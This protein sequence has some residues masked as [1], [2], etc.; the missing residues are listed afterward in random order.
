MSTDG[1]NILKVIKQTRSICEQISLLLRTIDEQMKKAGWNSEGNTAIV[2]SSLS[3]LQPLQWMPSD[4]FRFY[5]NE[6]CPN[7][8]AYVSVL[9]DDDKWK[10]YTIK[11]PLITAGFFD[12][13][14][15]KVGQQGDNWL[16]WYARYY[17][18]LA[19]EKGLNP[20]GH[21]FHFDPRTARTGDDWG[22]FESAEV[23]ALPLTTI[24]SSHDAKSKITDKLLELVNE[25]K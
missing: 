9:L 5:R 8:L 18:Y 21:P 19:K 3:I 10:E 12:Y 6:N 11:E 2:E 16:Y 1:E 24:T 20:D 17:G 14:Q 25:K 4:V 7:R 22:K 23:F 15:T 13:G